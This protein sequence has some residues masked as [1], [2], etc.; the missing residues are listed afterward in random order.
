MTRLL[1]RLWPDERALGELFA[2]ALLVYPFFDLA[3]VR[4]TLGVTTG[5]AAEPVVL[6][7]LCLAAALAWRSLSRRGFQWVSPAQLT[8]SDFGPG[9]RVRTL[10]RRLWADW[11]ARLGGLSYLWGL[12]ALVGGL[13]VPATLAGTAVLLSSAGLAAVLL[14]RLPTELTGAVELA[15][16]AVLAA[17]AVVALYG[18][19]T[20][21]L[22]A[23][24]AGLFGTLAGA[25][26]I[27]ARP[28]AARLGRAELVDRWANRVVRG[29]ATRFLDVLMLLPVGEPVS[30]RIT[31]RRP[32]LLRLELLR[33]LARRRFAV[34]ALLVAGLVAAGAAWGLS[35][36]WLFGLGGYFAVLPFTGGLGELYRSAGLRRWLGFD[37]KV[38]WRTWALLLTALVTLWTAVALLL[39]PAA[40]TP[41]LLLVVPLVALAV[42]RTVARDNASYDTSTATIELGG[43]P[44]PVAYL[45]NTFRGFLLLLFGLVL[46]G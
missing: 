18:L 42:L 27:G 41:A 37:L 16:P 15:L 23:A 6:A 4:L 28:A 17:L 39:A 13:S 25:A 38:I 1:T 8:W 30:R 20:P 32:V 45:A 2:V 14:W 5:P 40:F 7:V 43:G 44:I 33:L 36:V 10:G 26:L 22:L 12:L 3:D 19:L 9:G 46:L 29:T 24:V 31:L 34:P 35:P 11:A 21:V